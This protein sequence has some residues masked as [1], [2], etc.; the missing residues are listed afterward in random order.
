MRVMAR[1][2]AAIATPR[3]GR[4]FLFKVFTLA[5]IVGVVWLLWNAGN[6]REWLSANSERTRELEEIQ[7]LRDRVIALQ[8]QRKS[9]ALEGFEAERAARERLGLHKPGEKVIHIKPD[10]SA[11]RVASDAI[12]VPAGSRRTALDVST[13]A[14]VA[15]PAILDEVMRAPEPVANAADGS[16]T[17]RNGKKA[18]EEAARKA[19]RDAAAATRT[20]G[21]T[22]VTGSPSSAGARATGASAPRTGRVSSMYDA[23]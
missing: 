15:S 13:S 17:S 21:A 1:Y 3:G 4:F 12:T 11:Q 7:K 19:K 22:G 2:S 20:D 5:L 23:Q 18:K 9:L 8:A 10:A 14:S 6:L 16:R